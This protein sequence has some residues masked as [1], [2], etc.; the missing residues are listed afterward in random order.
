MPDSRIPLEADKYFHIYNHAIG[1]DNLF[2]IDKNYTFFLFNFKDYISPYADLAGYCLMPNHFHLI[3]RFHSFDAIQKVF[4]ERNIVKESNI[5]SDMMSELLSRQFSNFFNRYAKS[6]NKQEYRRGSLFMAAFKRKPVESDHYL[7]RLI[8]YVNMNPV[9]DNFV[10][11]APDWKYSSYSSLISLK[12]TLLIRDEVI[13]LFDGLEN[14]IF[15]HQQ[16]D[17]GFEY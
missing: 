11:S 3:V 1:T 6:F 15:F 7:R 12:P 13:E 14:F 9:K 10:N 8:R 17:D 16:N 4:L 5:D 2:T